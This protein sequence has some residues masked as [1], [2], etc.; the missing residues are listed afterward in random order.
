VVVMFLT[1][2]RHGPRTALSRPGR[3]A[4]FRTQLCFHIS[5]SRLLEFS[6]TVSR[7]ILEFGHGG[8]HDPKKSMLMPSDFGRQHE[9]GFRALGASLIDGISI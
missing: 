6:A 9:T 4:G 1:T 5:G 3:L 7:C 8:N 2:Y